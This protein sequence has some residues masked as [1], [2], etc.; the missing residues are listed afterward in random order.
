MR[1]FDSYPDQLWAL[2]Y[3]FSASKLWGFASLT[4]ILAVALVPAVNVV[5]VKSLSQAL[6]DSGP[7][8]ILLMAAGLLF[9]AG[10][11]LVQVSYAVSRINGLRINL[12]ATDQFDRTLA[13]VPP[14]MYESEEFMSI[15]RKARQCVSD[16]HPSSQFQAS[17]NIVSALLTAGSL[18]YTIYGMSARAALVSILAPIPTMIAY[19]WYGKQES[20]Y[21][22]ES[23]EAHRR[24]VYLQDQFAY[25][26]TGS[27]LSTMRA[28]VRLVTGAEASRRV[29]RS[30]REKLE[31]RSVIADTL[32]GL[33]TTI[34]FIL[35]LMFLY[36]D[37]GSDAGA[38]FA[39]IVG[40]M[41]GISAM[42]GV[43]YQ[44]GELA[45]SL[46]ANRHFRELLKRDMPRVD[47][48]TIV[49]AKSLCARGLE[50]RYG[51]V[52]A[53]KG[54]SLTAAKGT[55]CALVGENGSGKTS[56]IKALQG[57]QSDACG[58]VSID[59]EEFDVGSPDDWFMFACVQQDYGR[60]ELTVR[61]FVTLGV[62]DSR[63]SDSAISEALAFAEADSFVRELPQGV[64]SPLGVQWGGT[65]LSG[66]QWQRLAIARAVLTDAPVWFLDEPTSSIDAPTEQRIFDRL[67]EQARRRIIIL[68]SHRVS[69]L[70]AAGN[71]VVL[72][73]GEVCEQGSYSDVMREGTEFYRMF[74]TQLDKD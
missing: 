11:S 54:V 61:E 25:Q 26:R 55:L 40:L 47:A 5:V 38:I 34:L 56:V 45:I 37:T 19:G 10:S 43:G 64:D 72:K 36:Q 4:L 41:S 68:S 9:G 28:T 33:A 3:G 42:A 50:V 29:Y 67:A 18:G 73:A 2:R 53:V 27:E 30:I 44:I 21:W 8:L 52:T 12:Y 51:D 6:A 48:R 32:S 35:A 71:I 20:K 65:D 57:L 66:G 15:V 23:A 16:G 59:G 17:L 70:R 13:H 63:V 74:R 1:S 7:A 60:Y 62:S 24:S 58:R 46:P 14:K 69:T 22:P 49:G 39:G 31:G